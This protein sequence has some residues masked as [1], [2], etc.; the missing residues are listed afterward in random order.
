MVGGVLVPPTCCGC[1]RVG[2][3]LCADCRAQLR[4][5]VPLV[6]PPGVDEAFALLSYEGVAATAI[7]GAKFRHHREVLTLF[8]DALGRLVAGRLGAE[9]AGSGN[10]AVTWVPAL[11]ANRRRRGVDQ[12]ELIAARVAA[13]LGLPRRCLLRRTDGH[14]QLGLDRATRLAGPAIAGCAPAPTTVVLIDD[15]RTTGSSLRTGAMAL[16]CGGAERIVAATLAVTP[17]PKRLPGVYHPSANP[18][19]HGTKGDPVADPSEC[20]PY[21]SSRP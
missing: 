19:C 1:G 16:R 15:V 17:D 7:Q 4:P 5:A 8:A 18:P 14:S 3:V 12:G 20:T 10:A 13:V 21:L 9:L 6:S 11:A 2:H